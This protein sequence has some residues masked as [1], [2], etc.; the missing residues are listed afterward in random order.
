MLKVAGRGGRDLA[1][2]SRYPYIAHVDGAGHATLLGAGHADE[3]VK[4]ILFVRTA[5]TAKQ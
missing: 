5:A 1:R 3:I 2:A 4:A